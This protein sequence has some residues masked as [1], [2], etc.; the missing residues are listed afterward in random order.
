MPQAE[1]RAS[2]IFY[3]IIVSLVCTRVLG[4]NQSGHPSTGRTLSSL[5]SGHPAAPQFSGFG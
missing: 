3:T 5:V 1:L 4:K 2:Q